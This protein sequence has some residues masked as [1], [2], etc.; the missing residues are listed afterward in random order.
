MKT[1]YTLLAAAGLLL[2]TPAASR[3]SRPYTDTPTETASKSPAR[4]QRMAAKAATKATHKKS[5]AHRMRR[6]TSGLNRAF[7]VFLGLEESKAVTSPAKLNRQL[8]A[9]QKHLKV[10][11]RLEAKARRRRTERQF[12]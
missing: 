9:H 4:A 11:T 7:L 1:F 8:H 2:L 6:L 10:K 3:A 5:A 12:H